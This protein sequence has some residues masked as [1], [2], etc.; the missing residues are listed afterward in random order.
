MRTGTDVLH[1]TDW[2]RL[3]HARGIAADAPEALAPL[4]DWDEAGWCR[5]LDYL[6]EALLGGGGV[7]PATVPAVLFVAGLLDHPVADTV[8]PWEGPWPRTLRG[9]L[10][11]FLGAGARAASADLSDDEIGAAAEADEDVV[12]GLV[13][14][15]ADEDAA[16]DA[17]RREA[18]YTAVG[19]RAV[20]DLRA[21]APVLYEAVRPY[22]TD[23]DRHVRQRAVEAAGEFAFLAGLEPDLSGAVDLA[24]TRDEGAAIVLALG[25][26]GHDTTAYLT[27]ADPAIRTCA[28]LAPAVRGD[29]AAT[30]E[31]VSALLRGEE[32]E[33]WF[34]VRPGAFDGSVRSTLARE[35][36][37]RAGPEDREELRALAEG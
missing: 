22:L 21:A 30:R 15:V 34:S 11:E 5:A 6:Y 14:A 25:R 2:S 16:V 36:D 28:A 37:E 7:H 3:L 9:V 20:L 1:S 17:D 13:R 29:A 33:S 26:N 18:A 8:P 12:D 27:H 31:L 23:A 32:V 24:G 4:L 19:W 10:L 35:L